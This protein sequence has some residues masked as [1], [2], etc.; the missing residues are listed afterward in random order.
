[1]NINLGLTK[2][3]ENEQPP[4][5][6]ETNPILPAVRV[7]G[8][9]ASGRRCTLILR[10]SGPQRVT[11]QMPKRAAQKYLSLYCS[12]CYSPTVAS[13]PA[14]SCPS[15][16]PHLTSKRLQTFTLSNTYS[17]AIP[18]LFVNFYS[19]FVSFTTLSNVS[20]LPTPIFS[21]KSKVTPQLFFM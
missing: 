13:H 15:Q 9:P 1:M 19:L 18:P 6:G 7:A 5:P 20:R 12:I 2:N 4:R 14:N 3:Y 21:P 8:L 17:I 16:P 11:P 10:G